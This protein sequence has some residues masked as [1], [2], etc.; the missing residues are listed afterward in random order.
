MKD[1]AGK[2]GTVT[3]KVKPNNSLFLKMDKSR[4]IKKSSYRELPI[5]RE[6]ICM[7][8]STLNSVRR[9]SLYKKAHQLYCQV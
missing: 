5:C 8:K 2:S 1:T 6:S 3:D 7:Q 4:A 9:V